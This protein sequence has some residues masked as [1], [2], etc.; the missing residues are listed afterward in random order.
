MAR[1]SFETMPVEGSRDERTTARIINQAMGGKLNSVIDFTIPADSL[2]HTLVNPIFSAQSYVALMAMN[3][4]TVGLDL[5]I[6][7]SK[8]Q[9]VFSGTPPAGQA[10]DYRCLVIG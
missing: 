8:G 4:A 6:T 5:I 3:A 1:V 7:P 2:P 10:L 9:C